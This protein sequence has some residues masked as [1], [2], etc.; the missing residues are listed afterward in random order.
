MVQPMT[1]AVPE[2]ACAGNVGEHDIP[3]V[4]DDEGMYERPMPAM[5]PLVV[6]LQAQWNRNQPNEGDAKHPYCIK[7]C[8]KGEKCSR[9]P[10]CK[11][12]HHPDHQ[13]SRSRG[14][15][16]RDSII[17]KEREGDE[18]YQKLKDA[19]HRLFQKA[20]GHGKEDPMLMKAVK[21]I[22][23]ECLLMKNRKK[24]T[25]YKDKAP[26]KW[27]LGRLAHLNEKDN[28]SKIQDMIEAA[29]LELNERST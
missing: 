13:Q 8:N 1:G 10:N 9:I 20:K 6:A 22:G 15:K 23:D 7:P 5:P 26:E 18:D 19:V 12:C 28:R 24:T 4:T 25:E 29:I 17:K 14:Q 3:W 11:Y 21:R 2:L 27:L 16:R